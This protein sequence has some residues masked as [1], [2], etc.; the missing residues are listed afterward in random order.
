[1]HSTT[2]PEQKKKSATFENIDSDRCIVIFQLFVFH[3]TNI[4]SIECYCYCSHMKR[5][6]LCHAHTKILVIIYLR[7]PYTRNSAADRIGV[8][9]VIGSA[10]YN[11]R[12]DIFH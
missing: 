12:P 4:G 1:M 3:H 6:P 9:P 11:A 2:V 10:F 7:I 5:D 8:I